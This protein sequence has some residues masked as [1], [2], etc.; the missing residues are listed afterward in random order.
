[1]SQNVTSIQNSN[2]PQTLI[3][4]KS[5]VPRSTYCHVRV[6]AGDITAD[7][8]EGYTIPTHAPHHYVNVL[9]L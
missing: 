4:D 1:M 3:Y 9:A 8:D 6:R 2:F 7:P 5:P